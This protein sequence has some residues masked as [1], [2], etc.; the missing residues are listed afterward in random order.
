MMTWE[1]EAMNIVWAYNL[2]FN[3]ALA[4][5]NGLEQ[6]VWDIGRRRHDGI[7]IRYRIEFYMLFNLSDGI[8]K[9]DHSI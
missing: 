7:I 8:D 9:G 4:T 6:S 3:T 1:E 2:N 5:D